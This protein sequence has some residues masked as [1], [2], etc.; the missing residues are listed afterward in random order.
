[1][2][3]IVMAAGIIAY[4]TW[5]F[6][7]TRTMVDR[8]AEHNGLKVLDYSIMPFPPY[9]PIMVTLT[10]SRN[11]LIVRMR[12]YDDSIHRIRSGWLRLGSFWWGLTNID[13]VEVFWAGR[14]GLSDEHGF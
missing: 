5:W 9:P 11:Q 7:R 1:M 10:T 8:W 12:V 2:I 13:A 3:L 4:T 14:D 6:H